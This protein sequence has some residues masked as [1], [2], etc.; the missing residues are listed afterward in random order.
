MKDWKLVIRVVL[1]SNV[2]SR[3]NRV[4]L[5]LIDYWEIVE[6]FD[7]RG[8][9]RFN[10][11]S[12]YLLDSIFLILPY[13]W[14]PSGSQDIWGIVVSLFSRYCLSLTG[15]DPVMLSVLKHL[16]EKPRRTS[17]CDKI[18]FTTSYFPELSLCS[19]VFMN[20]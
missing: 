16:W 3:W 11:F 10:R 15:L 19:Q 13:L 14:N 20:K 12:S 18:N 7:G 17:S 8:C 6:L 9:E 1:V 5:R 2:L 4:H